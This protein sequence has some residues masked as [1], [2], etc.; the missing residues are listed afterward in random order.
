[1]PKRSAA[2]LAQRRDHIARAAADVLVRDGFTGFSTT[3]VC[4]QAGVSMGSLYGYF[5][6]KEAL[7][8]HLASQSLDARARWLTG[9]TLDE[10]RASIGDLIDF[11]GSDQG[12]RDVRLDGELGLARRAFPGLS[13][14]VAERSL[15]SEVHTALARVS[16]G[17]SAGDPDPVA[18][19]G[20]TSLIAGWT[21]L[22]FLGGD[23]PSTAP[24]AVDRV[25]DGT[26]SPC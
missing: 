22:V 16:D 2:H 13:A 20:I 14:L 7:L 11:L 6:S 21:Y 25:L 17:G 9:D 1:M 10:L 24:A 3:A 18:V 26:I 15:H 23:V 12:R 8:L 4:G 19:D 5:P